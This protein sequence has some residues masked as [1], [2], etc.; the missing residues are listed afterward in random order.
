MQTEHDDIHTKIG[1]R[2]RSSSSR[3]R[4]WSL[5]VKEEEEAVFIVIPSQMRIRPT[6]IRRN[7]DPNH[8][9]GVSR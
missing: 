7:T 4:K 1:G 8:V 3:N 2:R 5:L 6:R 9:F